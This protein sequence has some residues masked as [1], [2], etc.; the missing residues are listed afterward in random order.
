MTDWSAAR[1]KYPVAPV[2]WP[3]CLSL[4]LSEKF[5]TCL[6]QPKGFPV[7][8]EDHSFSRARILIPHAQIC[9]AL[10][11]ALRQFSCRFGYTSHTKLYA[12]INYRLVPLRYN[13]CSY[14][15]SVTDWDKDYTT[16]PFNAA[17][18][19]IQFWT[20]CGSHLKFVLTCPESLTVYTT[21]LEMSSAIRLTM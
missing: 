10:K 3:N 2:V 18:D 8:I 14:L 5:E 16:Y 19:F 21:M 7:V 11:H 15:T 13:L 9:Q 20:R 1:H 6:Y 17:I 4:N 12:I